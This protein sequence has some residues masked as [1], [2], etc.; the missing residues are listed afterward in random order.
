MAPSDRG[1]TR[2]TIPRL[3]HPQ[4]QT[5]RQPIGEVRPRQPVL[6]LRRRPP[7]RRDELSEITVALPVRRQQHQLRAIHQTYLRTH[8]QRQAVFLRR[9]V[10]ADDAGQRAFVR[11]GQRRIAQLRCPRHQLGRMRRAAQEREVREAMEFG[12]GG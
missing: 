5:P 9:F 2:H 11:D 3:R 7:P 8:H 12:E 1:N 4:H 6:P 10:R